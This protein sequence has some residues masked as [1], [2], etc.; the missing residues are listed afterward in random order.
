MTRKLTLPQFP[1]PPEEYDSRYLAEIVRSFSVYLQQMQNPG[2]GRYTAL[3]LS[4]LQDDDVGLRENDLFK[5]D[6]YIRISRLNVAFERGSQ[7]TG[8]VGTVTVSTP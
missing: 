1:V 8:A 2:D 3:N 7:A 4:D 5:K 6:G